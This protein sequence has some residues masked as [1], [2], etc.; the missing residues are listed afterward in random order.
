MQHWSQL[1]TRNWQIKKVRTFGAVLAVALGTAAVVWVSCCHESV[2][3]TV[4]EWA[5]GYVGSAHVTVASAWGPYDQ[6]PQRLVEQLS[7]LDNVA[8]ATPRLLLRRSCRPVRRE[9]LAAEPQTALQWTSDIPPVDLHGIDLDSEFAMRS[10]ALTAGR[11]LTKDDRYA[12]VLEAKFARQQRVGVGDYL[13]VWDPSSE[14][15]YEFEIVGLF[16]R[17]LLAKFQKPLALVRLAVLQDVTRKRALVT[18]IDVALKKAGRQ[19]VNEAA[20]RIRLKVKRIASNATVRSAEARMK[21]IEIAQ[22]NQRFV[23][24]M[25]GCVAMLTALFIILSTLSMGMVERVR[26]LGLLRCVGA[27]RAQLA[28]LVLIEVIP[29]GAI[30]VLSGVPIGLGLTAL[31]VWL[32]PEYVGSFVI[33]WSGIVLAGA[34]GLAT[35]FVAALLPAFAAGRVS[36]MEAARPRARRP[37]GLLLVVVGGLAVLM[38]AWQHFGLVARTVRDVNFLTMAAAAV[39]LLYFGYALL[40]PLVARLIGAPAVVVA[41]NL[42]RVRTRLLQDQVG[43]AVWRAAGICCGLMVGLS[44]IVGIVVVNESVTRGWQFPKQFPAAYLWTFEQMPPDAAERIAEV[45][46]VGAFTVAN[47]VNLIVEERRSLAEKLLLSVTW[48]MGVDPDSFLDLVKL[49]FLDG[50]GDERTARELLKQGGYVVIADD[51]SRS[52]NKHL[53]D[54]VKVWDERSSR[55]RRFKVAGVA[56]SPG[57]DIAAGYFQLDSQYNVVA[58]GSVMGTNEDLKRLFGIDGTN[59]VLLNFDLPDEPAPRGWPP[60]RDTLAARELSEDC[61]DASLPV[62]QRWRRWR[63][64]QVLREV[65]RKLG[66]AQVYSGTV[67]ELKDEIDRQLTSVTL[68]LAAIPSVAL[69]VAAIGVAN[70]MTANVAAR[71]KQLAILRAVG[72][73]RGLVLRMVVGEALVL[74]L[75]GSALGLALGLHLAANITDLVDRMWG[76]R[77]ALELPWR[78]VI[79]TIAL[80]VGLCIVAGILPARHASRANIVDALHVT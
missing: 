76:F 44:L 39:V 61:Y 48:F 19:Q 33:S 68:L 66:A 79:A 10:Y 57:L 71:A 15:P 65:R 52:R 40:A 17:R 37:R 3:R 42:L 6:I 41:A 5:T 11:M 56:R 36:P 18:T 80:T 38:L 45:P 28:C 14:R 58:A 2:R 4:M 73:T 34:A 74:G 75:L 23:L 69:L 24:V 47:S 64:E 31:T 51:F 1:A 67:A 32:V 16:E 43:H 22:N 29:L 77:V 21:Q 72:A 27:T 59:L 20:A 30:G 50:E 12:C 13:L 46:G 7:E 55:W 25:L 49:E 60:P 78:Y 62:E 35:T 54:E 26:Q 53:H 63:E 9:Q 70:L 8:L